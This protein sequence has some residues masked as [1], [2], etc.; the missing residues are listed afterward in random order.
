MKNLIRTLICDEQVSLTLADTTE[1][2]QRAQQLHGLKGEAAAVL[3]KFLS[4]AVFMSAALKEE[5]GEISFAL[6]GDGL[7]G[8]INV[9]GNYPL[10]IRGYM[11]GADAEGTEAEFLGQSGSFTVIRDDGYSRPFV[12]SCG[13]P[14]EGAVSVEGI[15][16]EYYRISEQLPTFFGCVVDL[17]AEGKVCFA[18]IAVLQPLPFTDEGTVEA[19]PKGEALCALVRE[20]GKRSV[21]E[22]AIDL[23]SAKKDGIKGKKATYTCNCSRS[24]LKQVLTSLGEAQ[25]RAIIREDGAVRVHCHYC[26]TDYAFDDKD[27]DEMFG[28]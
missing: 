22:V 18:G 14:S 16:E 2:V 6:Q 4:A 27:A 3:G 13:Y 11:E 10:H 25:M 17:D 9:S 5:S 26:N 20:M 28:K 24:Y 23:F 15:L 21:D 8:Q 7:A 12:G 19:L 1:L